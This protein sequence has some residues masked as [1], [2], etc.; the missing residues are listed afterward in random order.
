MLGCGEKL[1][2]LRVLIH[3]CLRRER[4]GFSR[5]A[6][7]R[8]AIV[9]GVISMGLKQRCVYVRGSLDVSLLFVNVQVV[10]RIAGEA[11]HNLML[12]ARPPHRSELVKGQLL[13]ETDQTRRGQ[14]VKALGVEDGDQ[15]STT[16]SKS[17]PAKHRWALLTAHTTASS[18]T[19]VAECR[20]SAGVTW[21]EPHWRIR[22][23]PEGC[24]CQSA[25]P[26]PFDWAASVSS[27]CSTYLVSPVRMTVIR[28]SAD[29]F[30]STTTMGLNHVSNSPTGTFSMTLFDTIDESC[31][32][33]ASRH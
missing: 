14:L 11:I 19:P 28:G 10:H 2:V 4:W 17:A 8:S 3:F 33:T 16:S 26:R 27:R 1:L 21:R 25:M 23:S 15:R 6:R 7:I 13:L 12:D 20:G 5:S 29:D 30:L 9:N 24:C 22:H 18:S 31:A 32:S